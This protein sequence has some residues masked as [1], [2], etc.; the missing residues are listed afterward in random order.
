MTRIPWATV[1]LAALAA[2][3][4]SENS[5]PS[6]DATPTVDAAPPDAIACDPPRVVFL[7]K[8]GGTFTRGFAVDSVENTLTTLL[9]EEDPEYVAER[10]PFSET[11][12]TDTVEQVR[13]LV[14]AYHIQVVDVDPGAVDHLEVV[15]TGSSWGGGA[16]IVAVIMQ[17]AC[18][19]ITPRDIAFVFA[20]AAGRE[21]SAFKAAWT[22]GMGGDLYTTL[23]NPCD[24]LHV[25]GSLAGCDVA[26]SFT[27]QDVQ[28]AWAIDEPTSC[29]CT[30]K[31]TQ[32]S[33]REMLHAYGSS[34]PGQ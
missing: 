18:D 11:D 27:D 4:C 19:E 22:I 24:L 14:T 12:W 15:M 34:C 6:D 13:S 9:S 29:P 31:P 32:N 8:N 20:N 3:G 1:F 10:W 2:P 5:T 26:P 16:G 30:Q 25:S 7:N 21:G 33:H 23:D 17:G 28:C